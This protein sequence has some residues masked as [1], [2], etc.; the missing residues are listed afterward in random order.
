M[1]WSLEIVSAMSVEEE[2]LESLEREWEADVESPASTDGTAV[3]R[4][5]KNEVVLSFIFLN[6]LVKLNM[7]IFGLDVL[8]VNDFVDFNFMSSNHRKKECWHR[9]TRTFL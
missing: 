2:P 7:F 5:M 8:V 1:G 3:D 4:R 6:F 9:L